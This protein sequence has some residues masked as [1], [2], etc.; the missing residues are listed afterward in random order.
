MKK[1]NRTRR[2]PWN[3]DS[4]MNLVKGKEGGF[5]GDGERKK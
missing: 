4:E 1:R 5:R 3:G 2:R